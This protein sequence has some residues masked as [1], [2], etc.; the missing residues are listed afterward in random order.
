MTPW[1]IHRPQRSHHVATHHVT[2]ILVEDQ[3]P[4]GRVGEAL[5]GFCPGGGFIDSD[6]FTLQHA[7]EDHPIGSCV[8]HN[9][10]A[11]ALLGEVFE[12]THHVIW[13]DGL[14]QHLGHAGL[15]AEALGLGEQVCC[16]GHNRQHPARRTGIASSKS[17]RQ[18]D[19]I[20]VG[21]VDVE[22]AEIDV[23][24]TNGVHGPFRTRGLRDA[25]A[26]V[27]QNT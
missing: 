23:T 10:D 4:V 22:Q 14:V 2:Q 25:K 6:P 13:L 20:F 9:Q 7:A 19:A 18:R 26:S 15:E 1:N 27:G 8:I 21:H 5:D 24:C 12:R 11:L 16:E 3:V 17:T